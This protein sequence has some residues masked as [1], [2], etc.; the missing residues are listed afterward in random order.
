MQ[1]G[2]RLAFIEQFECPQWFYV[3][4]LGEQHSNGSNAV[5]HQNLLNNGSFNWVILK[6]LRFH[7]I[8]DIYPSVAD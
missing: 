7:R 5:T 2:T 3:K 1:I 6:V 8:S 4:S